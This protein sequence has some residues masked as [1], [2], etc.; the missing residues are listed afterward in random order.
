MI[1]ETFVAS[2]RSIYKTYVCALEGMDRFIDFL[3]VWGT[4]SQS[5]TWTPEIWM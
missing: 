2:I 1:R 5:S 3:V 4:G